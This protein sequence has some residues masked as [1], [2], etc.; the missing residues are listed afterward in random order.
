M[1][2]EHKT[3]GTVRI[4]EACRDSCCAGELRADREAYWARLACFALEANDLMPAALGDL[5]VVRRVQA[6]GIINPDRLRPAPRGASMPQLIYGTAWKKNAT[7]T[8]ARRAM[9]AGF[10][11]FDTACQPKHY[12]EAALGAAL[13]GVSREHL[14]VQT[15]FT[16][17]GGH[18]E[19]V[20]Y[21]LGAPVEVQVWRGAASPRRASRTRLPLDARRG[22]VVTPRQSFNRSLENLGT[23][24]VDAYIMHTPFDT[25]E[26]TLRA[27]RAMEA[28][29]DRAQRLGIS[30]LYDLGVLEALWDAASV[31]PTVLQNR[32]YNRTNYDREI[33]RFCVE[34]GIQYM[35][36]RLPASTRVEAIT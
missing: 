28:V 24:Y 32:F 30:N 4:E 27:W 21:D 26:E 2:G 15:K 22:R 31:K 11:G 19:R 18:D 3:C 10:V 17:P 33:R 36:L 7:E 9:R 34:K 23:D 1:R 12:D 6:A 25:V 29:G 20:P 5:E 35:A 14:W 13:E 8:L 16:P